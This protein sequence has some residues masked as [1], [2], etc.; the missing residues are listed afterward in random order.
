VIGA[1]T[2]KGTWNNRCLFTSR[3]TTFL[4]GKRRTHVGG[5]INEM[6]V[7]RRRAFRR[8]GGEIDY[9]SGRPSRERDL[10]KLTGSK[11]EKQFLVQREGA[12]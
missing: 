6:G 1:V 11:E 3:G 2:R 8:R 10:L 4:Q 5:M 12:A 9:V 7:V